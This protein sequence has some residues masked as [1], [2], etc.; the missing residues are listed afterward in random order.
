VMPGT[1][2]TDGNSLRSSA[3]SQRS[4]AGGDQ[5]RGAFRVRC[6]GG[7]AVAAR[8]SASMRATTCALRE[9]RSEMI[10]IRRDGT[11]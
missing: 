8:P 1:F 5:R 2:A 10:Q 3:S 4:S 11:K 9:S 7:R 6:I